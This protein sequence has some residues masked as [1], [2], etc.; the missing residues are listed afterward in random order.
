MYLSIP[1]CLLPWELDMLL[2]SSRRHFSI[3]DTT[4]MFPA[5]DLRVNACKVLREP[6]LKARYNLFY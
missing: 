2:T 6:R 5:K 4:I 1:V 3:F